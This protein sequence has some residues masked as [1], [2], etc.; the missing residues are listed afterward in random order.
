[1][2]SQWLKLHLDISVLHGRRWKPYEI[3]NKDVTCEVDTHSTVHMET[4]TG[5][6]QGSVDVPTLLFTQ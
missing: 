6:I 4:G 5:F 3:S 1:M 2:E